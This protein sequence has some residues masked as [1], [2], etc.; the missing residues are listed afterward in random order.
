MQLK[1]RSTFDLRWQIL[2]TERRGN[3]GKVNADSF[4]GVVNKEMAGELEDALWDF[5]KTRREST[6]NHAELNFSRRLSVLRGVSRQFARTM[7]LKHAQCISSR[8]KWIAR[9]LEIK[10]CLK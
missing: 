9:A 8:T 10:E 2:D 4:V 3:R 7:Q 1:C 6:Q 5:S